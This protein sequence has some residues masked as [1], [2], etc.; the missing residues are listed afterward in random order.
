[1]KVRQII[2]GIG[3]TYMYVLDVDPSHGLL[4]TLLRKDGMI[5]DQH[6]AGPAT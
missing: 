3:T 2:G 1:M 6:A 4:R 5:F